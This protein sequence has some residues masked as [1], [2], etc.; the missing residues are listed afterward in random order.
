SIEYATHA[1]LINEK[2]NPGRGEFFGNVERR[3]VKKDFVKQVAFTTRTTKLDFADVDP[4]SASPLAQI[5]INSGTF[6]YLIRFRI[7]SESR[8]ILVSLN[9]KNQSKRVRLF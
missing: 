8:T 2:G 9:R 6:Q 3:E 1:I 5:G 7:Y 4:K